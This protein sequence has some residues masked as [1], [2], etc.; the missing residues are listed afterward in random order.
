[1]QIDMSEWPLI[2]MTPHDEHHPED[3]EHLEEMRRTT[4]TLMG[5]KE[6][7]VLIAAHPP[8]LEDFYRET[9]PTSSNIARTLPH[10]KHKQSNLV[11]GYISYTGNNGILDPEQ[12]A[13]SNAARALIVAPASLKCDVSS[14]RQSQCT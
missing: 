10:I 6:R 13:H 9:L 8:T 14:K 4:Q 11:A 12:P 3:A 7:F 5:S 2:W 1:M